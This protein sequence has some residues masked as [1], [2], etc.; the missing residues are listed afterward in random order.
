MC[1][2]RAIF[3]RYMWRFLLSPPVVTMLQKRAVSI[4]IVRLIQ[5]SILS[6][7][8]RLTDRDAQGIHRN[9]AQTPPAIDERM[10]ASMKARPLTRPS[11]V[12][13]SVSGASLEK[14]SSAANERAG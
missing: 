3:T 6:C 10:A 14:P 13:N 1:C 8:T 9:L 12:G 4:E 11:T 2:C 5:S 7:S